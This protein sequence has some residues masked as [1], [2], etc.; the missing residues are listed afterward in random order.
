M[1]ANRDAVTFVALG[2]QPRRLHW[3]QFQL[4]T[5]IVFMTIATIIFSA[6]FYIRRERHRARIA[7]VQR[8]MAKTRF[9][10][11]SFALRAFSFEHG[12]FPH[13]IRHAGNGNVVD[14]HD[15]PRAKALYSWRFAMI[16][17]L[18][19]AREFAFTVDFGESWNSYANQYWRPIALFFSSDLRERT[20]TCVFAIIGP[21][22]PF[23][24]GA[25]EAPHSTNEL[26]SDTILLVEVRNSGVHWMEPG[27]F[28]L[29]TLPHT[30]NAPDGRGISGEHAGGFFVAFADGEAWFLSNDV[31]FDELAKFF[32]ITGAKA[33]DRNVVLKPYELN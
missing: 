21:D 31:P 2:S 22:T 30:I 17:H 28:D 1:D 7:L 20:K 23:G 11:I 14:P 13:P 27:D 8:N 10:A 5:A 3:W 4:R 26:D 25:S 24:D 33:N 29:R 16:R 19:P 12:Q 9:R 32:T 6:V 18:A 15:D